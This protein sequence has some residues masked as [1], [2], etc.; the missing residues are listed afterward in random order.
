LRYWYITAEPLKRIRSYPNVGN[1]IEKKFKIPV[2]L[3]FRYRWYLLTYCSLW[4]PV[5]SIIPLLL[6]C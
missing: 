2:S 6:K 1:Q 5:S 4:V 3:H